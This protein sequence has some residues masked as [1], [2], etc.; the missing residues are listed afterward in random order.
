MHEYCTPL[1]INF[2]IVLCCVV[3][4]QVTIIQRLTFPPL[5]GIYTERIQTHF[6]QI[7]AR[8]TNVKNQIRTR[9]YALPYF[10]CTLNRSTSA[11]ISFMR[12]E[13]KGYRPCHFAPGFAPRFAPGVAPSFISVYIRVRTRVCTQVLHTGLHP[14]LHLGLHPLH[15]DGKTP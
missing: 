2:R 11:H 6:T 4:C 7:S 14:V 8:V 3:N 5:I 13:R 9:L 12:Y 10:L 15:P 1:A